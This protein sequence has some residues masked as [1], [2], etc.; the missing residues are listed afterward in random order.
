[1]LFH[2]HP[3]RVLVIG[4]GSGA[5]CGAALAHP[6]L[7]SLLC[8]EISPDVIEGSRYF[9]SINRRYWENPRTRIV[10]DDGRNFLF[11]SPSKWDVITSEPSNPWIAGIGSLY[12]EEFYDNCRERLAPG[13]ILC[14]WVHLY[15]MEESVLKTIVRTFMRLFP[16][17]LV[18]SSVE[19]FDIL[20]IGSRE[21]LLV[22]FGSLERRMGS[23]PVARDLSSIGISRLFTLLSTQVFDQEALRRWAGVGPVNTDNFPLVEYTAP[24]GFFHE[25]RVIL[26]GNS[27]LAGSRTLLGEYLRTHRATADELYEAARFQARGRPGNLVFSAL[28][29]ALELDPNHA[30]AL[31]M[32]A[33]LLIQREDYGEAGQV[34]KRLSDLGAGPEKETLELE[35]VVAV[36]LAERRSASFVKP[37]DYKRAL[38]IKKRLAE[39]EPGRSMHYYNLGEIYREVADYPQ[40]ARAFEIALELGAAGKSPDSPEERRIMLQ[41]GRCWLEA[42]QFEHAARWF[43]RLAREYPDDPLGPALLRQLAIEKMLTEEGVIDIKK[44]RKTLGD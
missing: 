17:A 6:E 29:D 4:A 39:L 15:E 11:R 2:S 1:M 44:L 23:E 36:K 32:M 40:A 10:I 30:G 41:I 18:F 20:L 25:S 26:P 42:K 33:Q 37:A 19:G 7:E 3:A 24:R 35:F 21:P 22:D 14:Q 27:R 5:T 38:E 13:G 34:I 9:A 31:R 43:E 28:S 16:E 12:A 8:V